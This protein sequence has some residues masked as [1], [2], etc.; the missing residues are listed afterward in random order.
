MQIT[1]GLSVNTQFSHGCE[2]LTFKSK[3]NIVQTQKSLEVSRVDFGFDPESK[4]STIGARVRKNVFNKCEIKLC[5]EKNI[6]IFNISI[7]DIITINDISIIT[8]L[9]K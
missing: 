7:N 4:L 2:I 9:Y 5:P 8:A 6:I 3:V 1:T